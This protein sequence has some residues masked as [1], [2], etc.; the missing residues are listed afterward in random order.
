M[1]RMLVTFCRHAPILEVLE[2]LKNLCMA[3]DFLLKGSSNHF[4]SSDSCFLHFAQKF[5]HTGCSVLSGMDTTCP[6]YT[7]YLWWLHRQHGCSEVL[8]MDGKQEHARRSPTA[9]SRTVL[10]KLMQSWYYVITPCIIAYVSNDLTAVL[11]VLT[12]EEIQSELT[13]E[14]GYHSQWLQPYGFFKFRNYM[15]LPGWVTVP[16]KNAHTWNISFLGYN[17]S[18]SK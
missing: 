4:I 11:E 16:Y 9:V 8:P 18:L 17:V 2:P 6:N 7:V 3:H 12:S 14:H 15:H 1:S 13:S 10:E 5:I